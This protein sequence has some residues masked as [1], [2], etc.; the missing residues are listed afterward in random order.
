MPVGSVFGL[1][2]RDKQWH[3]ILVSINVPEQV[4]R[5]SPSSAIPCMCTAL[6]SRPARARCAIAGCLAL[7]VPALARGIASIQIRLCTAR[8]RLSRVKAQDSKR[9]CISRQHTPSRAAIALRLAATLLY[10]STSTH[11]TS[12]CPTVLG[13]ASADSRSDSGSPQNDLRLHALMLECTS[14]GFSLQGLTPRH[15]VQENSADG[16]SANFVM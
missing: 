6:A 4:R 7:I 15:A 3:S 16:A 1:W 13:G 2:R 11:H 10:A 12:P 8:P 14:H 5:C 9:A